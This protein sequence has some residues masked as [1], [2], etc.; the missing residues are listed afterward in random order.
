MTETEMSPDPRDRAI[1]QFLM[2]M[3]AAAAEL[4]AAFTTRP[5]QPPDYREVLIGSMQRQVAGLLDVNGKDGVS[6][7]QI[8]ELLGRT[9]DGNVRNTLTRL[10]ELGVA[11]IVPGSSWPQLWR[12]TAPYRKGA[13]EAQ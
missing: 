11:E 6:P 8:T 12:H 3:S 13:S 1:A 4:A 9:D 5:T 7:R 2:T 10:R